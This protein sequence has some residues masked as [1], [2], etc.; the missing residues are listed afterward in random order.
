MISRSAT[1]P[2]AVS[3]SFGVPFDAC[4]LTTA[5]VT[6]SATSTERKAP[7]RLRRPERA[8]AIFGRSAPVA[9]EVAIALAVSWKPL[10]KSKPRAVT[11]TKTRMTVDSVTGSAS[12][13]KGQTWKTLVRAH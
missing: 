8:T 2:S 12:R 9:M 5:L 7:T 1:P 6:V 3:D 4:S 13:R 10:V 11:I